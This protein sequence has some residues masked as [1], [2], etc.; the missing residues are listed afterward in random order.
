MVG[1]PNLSCKGIK[2]GWLVNPV[3]VKWGLG[4]EV[5]RVEIPSLGGIMRK[6]GMGDRELGEIGIGDLN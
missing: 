3:R 4:M 1:N 6:G 5:G 2:G